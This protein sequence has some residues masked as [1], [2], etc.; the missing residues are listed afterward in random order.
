MTGSAPALRREPLDCLARACHDPPRRLLRVE[1]LGANPLQKLSE[2]DARRQRQAG[3]LGALPRQPRNFRVCLRRIRHGVKPLL[4]ASLA[5]LADFARHAQAL[6]NY[7]RVGLAV[8]SPLY[9]VLSFV[10]KL[11]RCAA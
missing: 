6:A 7:G 10:R 3:K 2:D 8:E 1:L 9:V 4:S 5:Q 11:S